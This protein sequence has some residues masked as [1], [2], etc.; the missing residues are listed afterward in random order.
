MHSYNEY[1]RMNI[2]LT[3]RKTARY[4]PKGIRA[5]KEVALDQKSE[6]QRFRFSWSIVLSSIS[7]P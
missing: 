6:V 2:T 1:T 3:S 4:S 5:T 7:V